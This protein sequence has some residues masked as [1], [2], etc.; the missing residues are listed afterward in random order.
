MLDFLLSLSLGSGCV[1]IAIASSL[2]AAIIWVRFRSSK[3][4][5]FFAL[6]TPLVLSYSLYWSP[7]WLGA[8]PS[9]YS[10]WAI[11]F[12]GPWFLAGAVS[13]ALVIFLITQRKGIANVEKHG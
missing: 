2:F 1:A 11:L 10:S 8:D 13:S 5:W 9:E 12:I 3:A 7:V 4:R 6:L